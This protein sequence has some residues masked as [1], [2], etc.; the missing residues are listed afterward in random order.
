MIVTS[1]KLKETMEEE[2]FRPVEAFPHTA[3]YGNMSIYPGGY[4]PWHWHPDVEFAWVLQGAMHVNTNNHSFLVRAGQGA[5]IN[6]NMLHNMEP[7]PGPDVIY[8]CQLFDVQ[9]LYGS[10]KSIFEQKYITPIIECKELEAMQLDLSE[11]NQRQILSLLQHSYDA[12]DRSDYGYEFVVRSDLSS[13]W[14]LLC[15]EAAPVLH[16]KKIMANPGEERVKKM[17]LYIHSHYREKIGLEEMAGAASIS[18]RECLRCFRQNLNTTPFTYLLEYR[19]RKAADELRDTDKPVTDIAYACG[20]SG[21]S[22]FSKIFRK[23]MKCTPSAYRR[24]QQEQ[25]KETAGREKE[26]YR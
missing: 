10:H 14:C 19:I 18:V 6:S 13:V 22:Y 25:S 11:P 21:T 4:V 9:L 8:L 17:L 1:V 12:A 16:A 15:Q 3:C 23:I 26:V 7:V 24:S 20:F 5:F 2:V